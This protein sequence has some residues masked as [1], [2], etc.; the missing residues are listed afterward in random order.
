[1]GYIMLLFIIFMH[2]MKKPPADGRTALLCMA[3]HKQAAAALDAAA[4]LE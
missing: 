2:K 1:M 3:A 4:A